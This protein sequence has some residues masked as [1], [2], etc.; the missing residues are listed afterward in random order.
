MRKRKVLRKGGLEGMEEAELQ[1]E[2]VKQASFFGLQIFRK[3]FGGSTL[4]DRY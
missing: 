3:L 1:A 2:S 4:S